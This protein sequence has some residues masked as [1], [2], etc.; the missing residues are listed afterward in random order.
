MP[1]PGGGGGG[2]WGPLLTF[3]RSDEILAVAAAYRVQNTFLVGFILFTVW[4]YFFN[5]LIEIG[6]WP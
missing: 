2:L 1:E 5:Q 6:I 3:N 4:K